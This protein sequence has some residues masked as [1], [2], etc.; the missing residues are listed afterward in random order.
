M[1]AEAD[2]KRKLEIAQATATAT[3]AKPGELSAK[4][5]KIATV[6]DQGNDMEVPELDKDAIANAYKTFMEK[7]G[8]PPRSP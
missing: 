7:M 1:E 6:A 8:G 5:V 4:R 3:Q 2:L